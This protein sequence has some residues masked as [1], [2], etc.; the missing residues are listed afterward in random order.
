MSSKKKDD[1][2]PTL[3]Q[4]YKSL[5]V[6][7]TA[8]YVIR[9]T[10]RDRRLVARDIKK[11]IDK[12]LIKRVD[13]G[14]YKVIQKLRGVTQCHPK[15]DIFSLHS[16]EFMLHVS[17]DQH[18][19]IKSMI[20]KNTQYFNVRSNRAGLYF[21]YGVDVTCLITKEKLFCFMPEHWQ[22]EA[23]NLR[24]L[25]LSMYEVIQS[26][27]IKFERKFKLLLFKDGR[28]NF[29]IRN[30]HIAIIHNG[31]VKEL[32]HHGINHLIVHD[33]ADGK[34]RFVLDWSEGIPHFEAIHPEKAMVDANE[35]KFMVDTLK[36]GKYRKMFNDSKSFFD[37]QDKISIS[38]LL[39]LHADMNK[40]LLQMMQY[41]SKT[42]ETVL[43]IS[44]QLDTTVK[45]LNVLANKKPTEHD[46][47]LDKD[48]SYIG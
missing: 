41:N 5:Q 24:D 16:L 23:D 43:A 15:K 35:A 12:G 17:S 19:V 32:K 27:C 30:M 40:T 48:P 29:D 26:I 42:N 6:N 46:I 31:I 36:G 34:P 22:L 44:T 21:D 20:I 14:L 7:P 18:K 33:N 10:C 39:K 8:K 13:R 9:Q 2:P 45:A 11:L 38:D 47:I 25:S 4:T 28:I 1:L 3:L 37:S